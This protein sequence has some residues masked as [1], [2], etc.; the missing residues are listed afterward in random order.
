MTAPARRV[1]ARFWT[2]PIDGHSTS[3]GLRPLHELTQTVEWRDG[4]AYC[5]TPGCG[6]TNTDPADQAADRRLVVDDGRRWWLLGGELW[7][8]TQLYRGRNARTV[9]AEYRRDLTAAERANGRPVA[10]TRHYLTVARLHVVAGPWTTVDAYQYDLVRSYGDALESR[11]G[12]N[13]AVGFPATPLGS[14]DLAE[15]LD[16]D[17]AA[18]IRADVR[19]TYLPSEAPQ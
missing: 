16:P 13:V 12:F 9:L 10:E 1:R 17:T 4:I 2:C 8:G 15:R 19:A 11:Y 18:H 7:G 14:V 6:R 5:L 3:R